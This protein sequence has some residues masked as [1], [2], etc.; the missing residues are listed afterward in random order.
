MGFASGE[1]GG[2]S[3]NL[4]I[5]S[6]VCTKFRSMFRIVTLLKHKLFPYMVRSMPDGIALPQQSVIVFFP[7]FSLILRTTPPITIPTPPPNCWFD[8]LG[9]YDDCSSN[10]LLQYVRRLQPK[11]SNLDQSVPNTCFHCL[12]DQ[13]LYSFSHLSPLQ[14]FTDRNNDFLTASRP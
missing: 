2:H 1:T 11:I 5:R 3:M 4:R 6:I 7:N 14:T 8:S 13:L 9:V 12:M 10:F